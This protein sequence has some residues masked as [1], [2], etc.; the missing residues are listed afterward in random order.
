MSTKRSRTA[1]AAEPSSSP[2]KR[3][4]VESSEPNKIVT[5]GKRKLLDVDEEVIEKPKK[6]PKKASL[7]VAAV[8][9]KS[10][11]K[12]AIDEGVAEDVSKPQKE[13]KKTRVKATKVDAGAAHSAGY[14]NI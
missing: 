8:T 12:I 10:S 13:V 5:R 11:K 2:K 6:S 1:S 3:A 7:V 9:R 4:S 14:D